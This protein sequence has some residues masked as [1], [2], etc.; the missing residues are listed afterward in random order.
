MGILLDLVILSIFVG[1]VIWNMRRGFW[2]ALIGTLLLFLSITFAALLYTPLINWFTA[3]LGNPQSG[4]TAGSI[5]FGG[6]LI[7]FYA[8][9]EYTVSRNYPEQKTS[10][11]RTWRSIGGGIVGIVWSA[12]L[13]SVILLVLD[14][15]S[16]TIG[17]QVTFIGQMLQ[18]SLLVNFFRKFFQIPL[19]PI[20]LLFPQG[21]PEIFVYFT[22]T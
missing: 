6:L 10:N 12:L 15:A 9:L 13:V 11:V 5:V 18:T 21:L 2:R 4:R 8:I 22:R 20:R 19:A 16:I 1:G 14:F 3:N 17:G 7:V